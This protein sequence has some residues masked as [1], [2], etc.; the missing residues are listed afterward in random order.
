MWCWEA[1][2]SVGCF[3][4]NLIEGMLQ[5]WQE[6]VKFGLDFYCNSTSIAISHFLNISDV[7]Y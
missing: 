2:I 3:S 6:P 5:R 1:D 4:K 7:I